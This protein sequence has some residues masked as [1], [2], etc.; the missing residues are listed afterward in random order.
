MWVI[1]PPSASYVEISFTGF[2][3]EGGYDFVKV[4]QC[5]DTVCASAEELQ[6]LSGY[7]G[8]KG[9]YYSNTGFMKV[10]FQS[11]GSYTQGGFSATFTGVSSAQMTT[12]EK[13]ICARTP[14]PYALRRAC[15][16]AYECTRNRH[17]A[18]T[19]TG[20][21]VNSCCTG[22][23]GLTEL[24]FLVLRT[25]K[26]HIAGH[27]SNTSCGAVSTRRPQLLH[28]VWSV[29]HVCFG[30]CKSRLVCW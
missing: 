1:A 23:V 14:S 11:D 29:L 22:R 17:V 18:L 12:I 27:W 9:P 15:T 16:R 5:Q 28:L 2:D 8:T 24:I 6:S 3:T 25:E 21:D 7:L 20:Y 26:E 10:T 19:V 13:I 4:Y 30:E